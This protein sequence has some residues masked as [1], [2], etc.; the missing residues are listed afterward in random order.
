MLYSSMLTCRTHVCSE[1]FE[2]CWLISPM[3]MFELLHP[4]MSTYINHS[5]LVVEI[6]TWPIGITEVYMSMRRTYWYISHGWRWYCALTIFQCWVLS[7]MRMEVIHIYVCRSWKTDRRWNINVI[8]V[9]IVFTHEIGFNMINVMKSRPGPMH[10][11]WYML[12]YLLLHIQVGLR[13]QTPT[14][15]HIVAT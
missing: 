6:L 11:G 10:Y 12:A 2:T 13:T 9:E 14:Y 4:S 8:H 1:T 3:D 7:T 5:P 15:A